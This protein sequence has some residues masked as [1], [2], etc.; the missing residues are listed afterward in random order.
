MRHVH[1]SWGAGVDSA[2]TS[3]RRDFSLAHRETRGSVQS[4]RRDAFRGLLE[5]RESEGPCL[6]HRAQGQ[7]LSPCCFLL[8]RASRRKC[9][10]FGLRPKACSLWRLNSCPP[11]VTVGPRSRAFLPLLRL[12]GAGFSV[13]D[14]G[15]ASF[16]ARGLSGWGRFLQAPSDASS[17]PCGPALSPCGFPVASVGVSFLGKESQGSPQASTIRP[18]P[19]VHPPFYR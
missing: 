3:V 9:S 15:A 13:G 5:G 2:S 18:L 12:W 8:F 11:S 6:L 4:T 7:L 17:C 1:V 19:S 14:M 16:C 10:L